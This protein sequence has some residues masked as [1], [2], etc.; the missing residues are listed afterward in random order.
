MSPA[1]DIPLEDLLRLP[2]V[3]LVG[4]PNVGKSRLFNRFAGTRRALVHNTPGITRDR[5]AAIVDL[6]GRE[7]RIVDTAG[8]DAGEGSDLAAAVQRQA[9]EAVREADGILFIVDG[10]AGL[11]PEDEAI[12]QTLRRT[13]RPIAVLVNKIDEPSQ[14]DRVH[15]FHRLGL[16][17][18]CGVSGEHG[19]GAF[20]AL[21]ALV[22]RL[23]EAQLGD[24]RC[25]DDVIRVAFV[26]R[27][28]VGKST[29]VNRLVGSERVVVS[30]EPGTT[31]DSVDIR[32]QRGEREY[33]LVDTA[34][35]RRAALRNQKIER[36][37]ALM[38]LRSLERADVAF[39]LVDA[40]EG[41]HD[42]DARI[43]NLAAESGCAMA[44]LANKWDRVPEGQGEAVRGSLE[45]A[46]GA[47]VQAPI[48]SLSGMTGMRAERVLPLAERV[49]AVAKRRIPTAELN[50]WL[51]E[52]IARHSPSMAQRGPRRRPIKFFFAT[53]TGVSPP[54]FV[55]V[56]TDPDAI[57]SSYRR[58]LEN[59]LRE[60]F[61]FE[62][63]PLRL[64]LRARPRRR[65][66]SASAED[67]AENSVE[68]T[69]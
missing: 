56:C 24:G 11:L 43:A 36:G 62:G 16:E 42:Q 2:V 14:L 39:L 10:R 54:R 4:R 40:S 22:A 13:D 55:L 64:Q 53:Q 68:Q 3:A 31:R 41:F 49:Y 28:N 9:R 66:G 67:T 32:I 63:A 5:I 48:L 29:L 58:F 57:Q 15:E 38:T 30:A 37:S 50:R 17:P 35:L 65:K 34:G 33:E 51:R 61:D 7:I 44:L 18:L 47:V 45:R 8:L 25:E 1:S 26:G 59:R 21:E 52:T 19:L 12:A 27:P 69:E 46:L 6:G 20:D 23:P 60:S